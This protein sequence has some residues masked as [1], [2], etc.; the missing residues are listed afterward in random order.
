MG[1]QKI[2]ALLA[3]FGATLIYGLNHTIAKVIMPEYIGA[4]GFICTIA[5]RWFIILG[6]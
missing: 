2:L 5:R 3:A 4:Y 6:D 1:R